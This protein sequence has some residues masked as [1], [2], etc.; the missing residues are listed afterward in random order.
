MILLEENATDNDSN[1]MIIEYKIR[2][3]KPADT[4]AGF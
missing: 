4:P 1:G 3:S 2:N